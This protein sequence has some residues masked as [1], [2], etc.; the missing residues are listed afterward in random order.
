MAELRNT[1]E[2]NSQ[3]GAET[4]NVEWKV[5]GNPKRS[6]GQSYKRFEAYFGATTV[7]EYLEAGGTKGDLRYDWQHGFLDLHP[8]DESGTASP[9]TEVTES[10]PTEAK[11]GKPGKAMT[12]KNK[13][14]GTEDETADSILG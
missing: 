9:V 5:K 6:H 8:V 11:D 7:K 12:A 1:K 2:W 4:T 13:H 10:A 3:N 14:A